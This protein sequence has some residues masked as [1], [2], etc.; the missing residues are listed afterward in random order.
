MRS[1]WISPWRLLNPSQ[2]LSRLARRDWC[3]KDVADTR[4]RER[5]REERIDAGYEVSRYAMICT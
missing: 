1:N 2:P 3:F 5:E 4:E